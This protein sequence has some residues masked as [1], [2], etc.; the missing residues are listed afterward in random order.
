MTN[1]G[2]SYGLTKEVQD[3]IQAS[4]DMDLEQKCKDWIA[5]VIGEPFPEE[6]TFQENLK[7]GKILCRLMQ[8]LAPQTPIKTNDSKM[9]FKQ[10]ENISHFLEGARKDLGVGAHDLFQT[11][12]LYDNSNMTQVLNGITAVARHARAKNKNLP[13]LGPDLSRENR[14]NFDEETLNKGHSILGMQAGAFK[15]A[16][17]EGMTF[18]RPRAL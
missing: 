9:A 7:D 5:T 12:D 11:T 16:T 3:K 2:P 14:R 6:G 1:R 8:T 15:G 4:Y 18:G 10:M 17:Q 13:P